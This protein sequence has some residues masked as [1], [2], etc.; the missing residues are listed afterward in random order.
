MEALSRLLRSLLVLLVP[1]MLIAALPAAASAR[2]SSPG[3]AGRSGSVIVVVRAASDMDAVAAEVRRAGGVIEARYR[4]NAYLVSAP[5]AVGDAS[6]AQRAGAIRGVRYATRN[7]MVHA[8]EGPVQG[9]ATASDPLYA[10]EW[11][12][13]AIGVPIAWDVTLGEGVPVAVL[14]T[15]I[16]FAH[17]DLVEAAVA[18][19]NYIT[20]GTAPQDDNGHGTHVAGIVAATRNN[21]L[22]IAGVAPK[23]KVY[24]V[25]VLDSRGDGSVATVASAIRDVVD[26]SPC[27][28]VSMSFGASDATAEDYRVL[29][30]ACDYARSKGAL[31]VAAAGNSGLEAP[32]YPASLPGVVGVGAID[33]TYHRAVFSNYGMGLIDLVAPGKGII[34]TVPGDRTA[35]MSGT[36]M[37][38]PF[39]SASA[40]LVWARYPALSG[41]QVV[42]LLESSS[43]DLGSPGIDAEYGYGLVRPDLAAAIDRPDVFEPDGAASASTATSFGVTYAHSLAPAGDTDYRR[44]DVRA[45]H[46]YRFF[47]YRLLRGADTAL[48]VLAADGVTVLASTTTSGQGD[49]SSLVTLT[50]DETGD[51]YVR[52]RDPH[53]TGGGYSVRAS[54]VTSLSVERL[55]GATR[56]DTARPHRREDVPRVDRGDRRRARERRGPRGGRPAVGRG[57]VQPV[58][59][60]SAADPRR[61]SLARGRGCDLVDARSG[62]GPHRGWDRLGLIRRRECA[63]AHA[64]GRPRRADRGRRSLRRG[65]ERGRSHPCGPALSGRSGAGRGARRERRPAQDL[66]RRALPLRGVELAGLPDPARQADLGARRH[67]RRAALAGALGGVGRRWDRH[68]E[69]RRRRGRGRHRTLAGAPRAYDTTVAVAEGAIARGWLRAESVALAA[70]LPDALTGGAALGSQ[71]TPVLVTPGSTLS[72]Q[73]TAFLRERSET[74][75]DVSVLGGTGSVS[76]ATM[77]SVFFVLD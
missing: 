59:R 34:S 38:T 25:K 72:P 2:T 20:P 77:D 39:V 65:G 69:R 12:L 64:R 55:G 74:V 52:V 22:D 60:A 16:D 11:G 50:A 76:S 28:I 31:V 24:A 18:F 27:R 14:D 73:A 26:Y 40:A 41:Q 62:D 68:R 17:R 42:D 43:L 6:F 35:T 3:T 10:D 13:P 63:R 8:V 1:A 33:Q 47:T 21:D 48:D 7:A 30:D 53:G 45:G 54:D 75:R 37:A 15:G 4:W 57:P 56:Y 5:S 51:L 58:P 71:G 49:P 19:R 9:A 29:K 67:L 44:L 61:R 36:S 23:A 66:L 32:F 46:S 70:K